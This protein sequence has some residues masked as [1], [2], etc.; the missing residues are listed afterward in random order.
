MQLPFC[1]ILVVNFNG[2]QHLEACLHAF[3]QLDYPQDRVEILLIDNGSDDGSELAAQANHPRVGLLRNSSNNFA[4]ALNLGV[5]QS[6]G[7]YVAFANND[8]F[9]DP[10]WLVQLVEVLE[11]NPRVGCTGGKILFDNGRINSVGHHALPDF[12][13]EDEGYNEEDRGQYDTESE[14]EGLCWAAVLFRR[15]CLADVGA[16]DED[17]VMYYEDVDMSLRCLQR[18][19]KILYRPRAVARHV[20]HGSS[21]GSRLVEYFCDR[22]RLIYV[23]KHHPEALAKAIESSRFLINQ[24]RQSFYNALPVVLKKLFLYYSKQT[25]ERTLED[26]CAALLPL[27]GGL[28]VDHLLAR[29]QVILGRRKMSIG[30]YDQAMHVIGGGQKYG[31]TMAAAL[32]DRFDVTLMTNKPVTLPKLEGWYGLSLS[33]C[34]LEII[35]MPFFEKHGGWIDSNVVTPDDANPFET[36]SRASQRFDIFV[37]VNMLTMVRPVSPFSIFLCHFPDT[38]R[39]CYFAVDEYSCLFVNSLYTAQWVKARWG[40]DPDGLLYPPVD[41]TVPPA[42]KENLI[43]SVARFETGGSK[44]QHELIRAF[45]LLRKSYPDLLEGWRLVLA[46]GSSPQNRYL[47]EIERTARKS[48]APIAVH[49]DLSLSKLQNLYA[50]AKIFWHACGLG[51]DD[52]HLIEHFGMSIVEAMQNRCVPIVFNGGGQREIVEH[53]RSGYRFDT[54]ADL[55]QYSREVIATP[56]L[57]L[58]LQEAAYE[59][60]QAFARKHFE[61]FVKRFFG[62]LENEYRKISVPDPRDILRNRRRGNLFYSPVARRTHLAWRQ[63]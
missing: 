45:E 56:S 12:Y 40:L 38:L 9:V 44:K 57:M 20:F 4:S 13:W 7:S 25:F 59:R 51:E 30:F 10:E 8:V 19:W 39:R 53:A 15:A 50:R 49:P 1:S 32:Q 16:I 43:L 22:N 42:E 21:H 52:P 61:E 5:A 23:A 18:G 62:A 37:N 35:P 14:R 63:T 17:F 3:E 34:Q 29:M 48:P 2:E 41:M 28:A 60:S 26:V 36:I 31:C 58:K 6:K 11:A 24:D 33:G 47:A 46:G 54:L 55:C 27:Y